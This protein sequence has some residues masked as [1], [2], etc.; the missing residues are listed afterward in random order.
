MK[1]PRV[2]DFDPDAK[3]PELVSPL[4]HMP[5][6]Q[7]PTEKPLVSQTISKD[8]H[9]EHTEPYART[10]VRPYERSDG[11]TNVR[12]VLTRYAFEFYQDQVEQL[13]RISL[14]GKM[15]G[16]KLSMSEMVREALDEYLAKKTKQTD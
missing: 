9:V 1:T 6:I 16:E 4:D 2:H 11:R 8:I 13:R 12:R 10:Y 7:K 14:E 15:Q 3:V 5:A